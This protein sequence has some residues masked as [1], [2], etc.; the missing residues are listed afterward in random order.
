MVIKEV[1]VKDVLQAL[2]KFGAGWVLAFYLVYMMVNRVAPAIEAV[3]G[4]MLTHSIQTDEVRTALGR[5]IQIATADCVN[6]SKTNEQ[7][8]RCLR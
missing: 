1:G 3:S 2:A 8:E 5:L 6:A 7:R 4:Q